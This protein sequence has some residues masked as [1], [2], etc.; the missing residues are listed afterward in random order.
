M[1]IVYAGLLFVLARGNSE[2]LNEAKRAL[3]NVLIGVGLVL[4]ATTLMQ[5]LVYTIQQIGVSPGGAC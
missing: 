5:V 2:K 3:V 1:A 4:I